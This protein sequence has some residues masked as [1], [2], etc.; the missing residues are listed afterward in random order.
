MHPGLQAQYAEE[1]ERVA[2]AGPQ[3]ATGDRGTRE[4]VKIIRD[5]R[6]SPPTGWTPVP[7]GQQLRPAPEAQCDQGTAP[8]AE[9]SGSRTRLG[10][11]R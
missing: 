8:G 2:R 5:T 9:H 1:V 4:L 6:P 10:W 11:L 3:Q 7:G